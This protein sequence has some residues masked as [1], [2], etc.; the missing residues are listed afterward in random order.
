MS[1]YEYDPLQTQ[2][3]HNVALKIIISKMQIEQ[4]A[5]DPVKL[6][7]REGKEAPELMREV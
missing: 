2:S 6:T 4:V 5:R 1:P 3:N 7:W